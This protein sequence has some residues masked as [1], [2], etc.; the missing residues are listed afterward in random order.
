MNQLKI[1]AQDEAT[2]AI[3]H[4]TRCVCFLFDFDHR[5]FTFIRHSSPSLCA[6]VKRAAQAF[7]AT[8]LDFGN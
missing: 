2:V 8:I 6:I 4:D 5:S 3:A 1:E 7:F